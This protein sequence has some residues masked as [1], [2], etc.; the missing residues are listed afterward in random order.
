[1]AERRVTCYYFYVW[2]ERWGSGFIKV[3]AYF[4]YPVKVWLNGHEHSNQVSPDAQF[5]DEGAV[6]GE[7][8][9]ALKGPAGWVSAGPWCAWWRRGGQSDVTSVTAMRALAWSAMALRAA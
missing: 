4:P 5:E 7:D 3:C 1:M 9:G 6:G 8:V 2:D